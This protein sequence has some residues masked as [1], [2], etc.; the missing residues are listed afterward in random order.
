MNSVLVA[1]IYFE[2][3]AKIYSSPVGEKVKWISLVFLL[4]MVVF[5]VYFFLLDDVSTMWKLVL[6][7]GEVIL[8]FGIMPFMVRGYEISPHELT[9]YRF[10]WKKKI[11]LNGL[12]SAWHHKKALSGCWKLIGNDGLLVMHG[13]FNHSK[14][15]KFTAFVTDT[16]RV[17][18]MEFEKKKYAISPDNPESFITNLEIK[19]NKTL[20]KDPSNL[21]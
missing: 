4:V 15:G 6:L 5:D 2:Y 14:I 21:T 17:V 11:P 19:L 13:L 16:S 3:M 20:S 1:F 10:F 9:I 8:L 12:I 18:V 7:G